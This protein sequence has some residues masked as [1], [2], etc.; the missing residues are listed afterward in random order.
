MALTLVTSDLIL[1]LD[2]GKL[3]GTIPT[4]NQNTTGNADTATLAA[5]ATILATA[6]NINSVAF[7]GSAD[8]TIVDATKLP[9]AGGTLTGTLSGTSATFSS[10]V[11]SS[12]TITAKDTTNDASVLMTGLDGAYGLIQANNAA[13]SLTKNLVLQKYGGNV[14][15][16]TSSPDQKLTIQASGG[17]GLI[18]YKKSDATTIAY[19]GISDG[20]GNIISTSSAGDLCLRVDGTNAVLFSSA[21]NAER[22]RIS[23]GGNV[24]I[25]TTNPTGKLMIEATGNHLFLRASTATAGKYW[26]LDVTSANQLYI[27]NNAGTQYLTIT[28]GGNVGIGTPSP[29]Y[30]LHVS[31]NTNGFISRFTGGTSSDVNIG[32]FGSTAGAFGSIGTESNHPF[33][34]FTNGTDRLTIASTGDVQATRAR[35]NTVGDVA[36]SINPSDSTIHYGFRVDSTT[37][38]LNLDN[39]TASTNLLAVTSGG[40]I[41]INAGNGNQLYLNNSGERYTQITFDH[42]TSGSSQAYLAWDN[43]NSFFEMYAKSGGGLKFFTN[44]TERVAIT[45]G[46][47]LQAKYG[48]SFPS[49]ANTSDPAYYSGASTLNGYE[50]GSWT[51]TLQGAVTAGSYTLSGNFGYYT[52]IGRL[53]TLTCNFSVSS[54][55]SAGTAYATVTGL[56]Y[57]K[58]NNRQANGV[59]VILNITTLG[60]WCTV[61]FQTY[62]ASSILY[63]LGSGS[64]GGDLQISSFVVGTIVQFTITYEIS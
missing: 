26:A 14:G 61:Q 30:K 49:P 50:E 33:N 24:G 21:G 31:N 15:I 3:T 54:I 51:P 58:A 43:T 46:G 32:I 2:Y 52:R 23:S 20:A 4:W 1:G 25:G 62:G 7:D 35:S 34:I 56:P 13:G 41:K 29:G 60:Q 6:R 19:V 28:D 17:Y 44:A 16:G 39:V 48:I 9:L 45:S 11:T 38:N 36:L 64:G 8:I 12:G 40:Q 59:V 53:V 42:N 63:F 57:Q 47:V 37:N 22:M 5:G 27:L 55:G 18:S 10:S